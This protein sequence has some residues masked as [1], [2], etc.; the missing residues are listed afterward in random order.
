MIVLTVLEDSWLARS[1][2]GMEVS[3]PAFGRYGVPGGC[4][5]HDGIWWNGKANAE[6]SRLGENYR[7]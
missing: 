6:V 5:G 1:I 3:N 4:A 7:S 2:D